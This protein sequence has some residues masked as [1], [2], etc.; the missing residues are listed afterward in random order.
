MERVY[1]DLG[2]EISSEK[3]QDFQTHGTLIYIYLECILHYS[4]FN[5]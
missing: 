2:Q 1:F 4:S 3:F 5:K